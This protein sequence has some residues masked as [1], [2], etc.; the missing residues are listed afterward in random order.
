MSAPQEIRPRPIAEAFK[1]VGSAVALVGSVIVTLVSYGLLTPEQGNALGDLAAAVPGLVT[2][3]TVALAAFGVVRRAE[4]QTTP[5]VDPAVEVYDP[6]R[7]TQL[8][9]LRPELHR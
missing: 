5:V 3:V 4:P 8:V 1:S 9:K 7:G 2:L 6:V